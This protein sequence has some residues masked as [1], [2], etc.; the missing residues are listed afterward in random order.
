MKHVFFNTMMV[1]MLMALSVKVATAQQ[2][3]VYINPG[4]QGV[5]LIDIQGRSIKAAGGNCLNVAD[6][7]PGIYIV[8][9]HI[10][11]MTSTR[12]VVIN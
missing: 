12:K 9:V 11:G 8:R 10:N 2:P 1:A 3:H 7:E 6:V 5:E 4:V